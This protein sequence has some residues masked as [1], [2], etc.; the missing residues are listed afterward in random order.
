MID[1]LVLILFCMYTRQK[2]E[3]NG[4]RGWVAIVYTIV[5]WF[6]LKYMG[7]LTAAALYTSYTLYYVLTYGFAVIGALIAVLIS[8]LASI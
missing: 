2:A 8:R 3:N 5:L 4:R 7:G 1:I 6:A